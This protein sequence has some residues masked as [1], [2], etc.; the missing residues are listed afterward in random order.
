MICLHQFTE[1]MKKVT[2]T[3]KIK[4]TLQISLE[5]ISKLT[6]LIE[7]IQPNQ[8]ITCIWLLF[9]RPLLLGNFFGNWVFQFFKL[10]PKGL[11]P[12][13]NDFLAKVT[14]SMKNKNRI[15]SPSDFLLLS[16]TRHPKWRTK[17]DTQ[18]ASW[19]YRASNQEPTACQPGLSYLTR[20]D[21]EGASNIAY[22]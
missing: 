20:P 21:S 6:L 9:L 18:S 15:I 8:W 7:L 12:S 13:N 14:I 4:W 11:A 19:I 16:S 17:V 1:P 22:C 3:R 5:S 2:Q 10:L